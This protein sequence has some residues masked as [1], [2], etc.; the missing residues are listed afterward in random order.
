LQ[1]LQTLNDQFG[2]FSAK[3]LNLAARELRQGPEKQAAWLHELTARVEPALEALGSAGD[4]QH[5]EWGDEDEEA[6]KDREEL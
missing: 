5:D 4:D 2:V 6:L 3:E 1:A